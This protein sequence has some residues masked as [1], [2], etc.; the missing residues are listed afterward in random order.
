M[1]IHSVS[2]PKC[3]SLFNDGAITFTSEINYDSPGD[4]D[5]TIFSYYFVSPMDGSEILFYSYVPLRTIT[6]DL[7]V[8]GNINTDVIA[9]LVRYYG[10]SAYTIIAKITIQDDPELNGEY[11]I[12]EQ[13]IQFQD[14]IPDIE[15]DSVNTDAGMGKINISVPYWNNECMRLS[16]ELDDSNGV[17]Y[18]SFTYDVVNEVW[19]GSA[20]FSIYI[21]VCNQPIEMTLVGEYSESCAQLPCD[22]WSYE[23]IISDPILGGCMNMMFLS[24]LTNN[25]IADGSSTNRVE[26]SILDGSTLA[27]V[28]GET[29]IFTIDSGSA[30][31][32]NGSQLYRSSTDINGACDVLLTNKIVEVVTVTALTTSGSLS[33]DVTFT[34]N[35]SE[36]KISSVTT[37]TNKN[38]ATGEPTTAWN[39]AN[40]KLLLSGGSGSY[41]W[42]IDGRGLAI[43]ETLSN[44]VI[45]QF[46]NNAE[47]AQ[48]YLITVTDDTTSATASYTFILSDFYESYDDLRTIHSINLASEGKYLPSPS[49]LQNLVGEWGPMSNYGWTTHKEVYWTSQFDLLGAVATLV[50]VDTG[51]EETVLDTFYLASFAKLKLDL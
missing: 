22:S 20:E 7:P 9:G 40:I 5:Y 12:T 14:V 3:G 23:E 26:L 44:G 34:S 41:T 50:N 51:V 10:M 35:A 32:S 21:G 25:A 38:F 17:F 37:T 47:T 24:V 15:V 6:T 46:N 43:S 39:G 45:L 30:L 33:K 42:S 48:S 36:L 2:V 31:F 8:V 11:L 4:V 29:V 19:V 28:Q 18:F 27:P 16:V 1:T 13:E 49:Q